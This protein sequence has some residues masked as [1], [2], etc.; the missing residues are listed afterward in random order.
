MVT[1]SNQNVSPNETKEILKDL[2]SSHV[3]NSWIET[4]FLEDK[5]K[6]TRQRELRALWGDKR[7]ADFD[8]VPYPTVDFS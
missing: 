4:R 2:I 7:F 3:R 1:F 5:K 8:A 6:M